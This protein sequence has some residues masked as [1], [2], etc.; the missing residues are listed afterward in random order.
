MPNKSLITSILELSGRSELRLLSC[1][2]YLSV[3]ATATVRKALAKAWPRRLAPYLA[4]VALVLLAAPS[5]AGVLATC[6]G[7]EGMTYVFEGG[8]VEAGSDGWQKDGISKGT[9]Q[10][11]QDGDDLDLIIGD[12]T[13]GTRSAKADG[14][15]VVLLAAPDRGPVVGAFYPMAVEVYDFDLTHHQV[16]WTQTKFS[17]LVDKTSIFVAPCG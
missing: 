2:P 10:L 5:H 1:R 6:G 4:A 13:G 17:G 8:L 15:T 9:I 7:S 14:A 12:S 11:L 16:S 3:T